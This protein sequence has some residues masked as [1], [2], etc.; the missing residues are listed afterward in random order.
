M[1]CHLRE[2]GYEYKED[3]LSGT[4]AAVKGGYTSVACMP[5][6]NPA[7]DCAALVKYVYARAKGCGYAKVY[8]IACITKGQKGTE[9]TETGELKE[10]GAVALSDDGNPVE[11]PLIM[12]NAMLYADINP[13]S[14]RPSFS[15]FIRA[16][17][18]I[19][20][21]NRSTRASAMRS[22]KR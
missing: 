6:T 16:T 15:F 8:P 20:R 21:S 5:N 1:H 4:M 22:G 17:A 7:I 19:A 3:I 13:F 2:P 9:L 18:C 11:N 12:Q 10:A 14:S